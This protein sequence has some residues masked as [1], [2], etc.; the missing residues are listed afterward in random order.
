MV[1]LKTCKPEWATM[2]SVVVIC[3]CCRE[4]IRRLRINDSWLYMPRKNRVELNRGRFQAQGAGL[5]KSRPWAQEAIPT[6]PD[7]HGFLEE[8]KAQLTPSELQAR[9]T[10]F[11]RA[12]KWVD[13]APALGYRIGKVVRTSFQ[14]YPPVRDIRLDGEIHCGAAFKD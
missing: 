4:Y 10:C 6:K 3:L 7:G 1:V 14:P 5:E 12:N 13:A 8:L 9:A 11:M 2:A